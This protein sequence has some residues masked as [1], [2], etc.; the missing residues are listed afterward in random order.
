MKNLSILLGDDELFA[1]TISFFEQN[2][3]KRIQD[4]LPDYRLNWEYQMKPERVIEKARTGKYDVVITDLDYGDC[5]DGSHK[6]G[7]QIIDEVSKLNP[8]PL[9][10]LCTSKKQDEEMTQR[11]NEKVDFIAGMEKTHKWNTL[12]DVLIKHFQNLKRGNE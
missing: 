1:S 9:L 5:G 6:D 10:I 4:E 2:Q 11:T 8:K 12:A 7:Y 3:A